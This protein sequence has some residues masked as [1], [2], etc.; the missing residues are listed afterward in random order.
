MTQPK[1]ESPPPELTEEECA[2]WSEHNKCCHD[3]AG[4]LTTI[5]T[6]R[7]ARIEAEAALDRCSSAEGARFKENADLRAKLAEADMEQI[8][9]S[10]QREDAAKDIADLRAKLAE[11]EARLVATLTGDLK[12]AEAAVRAINQE[13]D[14]LKTDLVRSEHIAMERRNEVNALRADLARVTAENEEH[15][16]RFS[17]MSP[18]QALH[19]ERAL[20]DEVVAALERALYAPTV[21]YQKSARIH[22]EG[23]LAKHAAAREVKT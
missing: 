3:I 12:A 18:W 21:P 8:A 4:L 20:C 15:R 17:E 9:C 1:T 16:R 23:V 14:A 13:R 7:R 5:A 19:A 10:I 22:A 6:E 11:A 2:M